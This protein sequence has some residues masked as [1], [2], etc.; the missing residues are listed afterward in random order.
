MPP[1]DSRDDQLRQRYGPRGGACISTTPTFLASLST[2]TGGRPFY[3]MPRPHS[4]PLGDERLWVASSW[5]W[6][7][8]I[9]TAVLTVAA[10]GMRMCLLARGKR[11]MTSCFKSV[12]NRSCVFSNGGRLSRKGNCNE[13][14][15]C[16]HPLECCSVCIWLPC[17]DDATAI[18]IHAM[19][20]RTARSFAYVCI[21]CSFPGLPYEFPIAS[22]GKRTYGDW[23]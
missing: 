8:V 22:G 10:F 4:L 1:L 19:I 20:V 2:L 18:L 5:I 13:L 15:V 12:L 9:I 11:A 16:Q 6:L 23:F 17:M 21:S 3:T 7:Y 14:P